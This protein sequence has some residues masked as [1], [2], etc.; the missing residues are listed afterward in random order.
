MRKFSRDWGYKIDYAKA[1][2][3]DDLRIA[4]VLR[5]I[6]RGWYR[7]PLPYQDGSG[8]HDVMDLWMLVLYFRDVS[9]SLGLSD[10]DV[11][12]YAAFLEENVWVRFPDLPPE[13][14]GRAG[15]ER[16]KAIHA[17]IEQFSGNWLHAYRVD[18]TRIHG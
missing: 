12:D 4:F 18:A 13:Q 15:Y 16:G 14:P 1:I 7:R 8:V 10:Q 9:A 5:S 11:A 17:Q 6:E 3:D 2:A